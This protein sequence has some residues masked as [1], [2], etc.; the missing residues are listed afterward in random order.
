MLIHK[1]AAYYYDQILL[2]LVLFVPKGM[3]YYIVF[4]HM[5]QVQI[6]FHYYYS[7]N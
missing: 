2:L 6:H 3:D 1:K 7:R 4:H 5:D